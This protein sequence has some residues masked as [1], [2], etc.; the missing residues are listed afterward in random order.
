MM[1]K[2]TGSTTLLST[3]LRHD[4]PASIVVFLVAL[5]LSIGI[6][7]ASGA[8]VEAGLLA[9]IV[10]GLVAGSLG[11]SP[12]QVSGPAAG[13]TVVV[14][15]LIDNLG[16]QTTCLVTAGAGILQILFGVG[17]IGRAALAIAPVVVHA[18]LA[19]I[20]I[21]IALQQSHV[22][23]GGTPAGGA[24][25]NLIEL[26]GQIMDLHAVGVL[27]G[28]IVIAIMIAWRFVP[29]SLRRV[30]GPLVAVLTATLLSLPFNLDRITLSGSL[31]DAVQ[32]PSLPS[33]S[34]GPV[35][36]GI[37]TVALI[38]SVES[39]LCAVAIGKASRGPRTNFDR[40]LIG[41][42]AANFVSGLI[43]G[44]PITGVI[45][46]SS[47]NVAAG[48][49][50]R[51]SAV[52]HG[53][54]VLLFSAALAG[55]VQQIPKAVL[56]GLLIVIGTQLVNLAHIKMAHRTGDLLTYA[57]TVISV[58]SLNL[59]EGVLIGLAVAFVALLW[60]IVRAEIHAEPIGGD[61]SKWQVTI[62]GTCTF[63]ALPRL[64]STL[65]KV[66]P[67]VEVTVYTNVDYLDHA[68]YD[69]ISEW[70]RHHQEDTGGRVRSR[71]HGSMR[72]ANIFDRPPVKDITPR[73]RSDLRAE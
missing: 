10:G 51:A 49:R 66:P 63:L 25:P 55:V 4:V 34:W 67:G 71:E 50:T 21:T 26:P 61:N 31:F 36:V 30:P 27:F 19:G 18:M 32:L 73:P 39:L 15:E 46:R 69:A 40:E 17:R 70:V 52:L 5:P 13:L 65:A 37:L 72:I 62:A 47:A 68:A 43:G 23:L 7:V 24:V 3:V 45:V 29:P 11:G 41:Q 44:L 38:A 16:W 9:A 42:G 14:A 58:V 57:V 8:P 6:A 59:L 22:L 64:S 48:A 1:S 56:A 20:G 54:W 35:A 2:A 12:M 28:A 53:F 60:R 33:G